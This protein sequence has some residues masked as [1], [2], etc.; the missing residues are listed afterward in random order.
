LIE[1]GHRVT[2]YTRGRALALL[3]GELGERCDYIEGVGYPVPYVRGQHGFVAKFM[4]FIPLIASAIRAEHRDVRRIVDE[5][6][7]DIV[8]GDG[9]YGLFDE[10]IPSYLLA[11]QLRLIAPGRAGLLELVTE[12]FQYHFHKQFRRY[13]VPDYEHDSLTGDLSHNLRLFDDN[14]ISYIGILS[15]FRRAD[16]PS[17]IDYFVSISG[18]EPSRTTFEKE[19]LSQV[20]YL[21]GRVVVALGKPE[22]SDVVT[23]GD[24]DIHS[25]VNGKGGNEFM[26]RAK[27][28]ISRPGYSTLMDLVELGKKALF[29]PTPGQTEQEYLAQYHRQ[30]GTFYSVAQNEINLKLDTELAARYPGAACQHGTA[31]SVRKFMEVVFG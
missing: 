12:Y 29:I 4:S 1:D 13:I 17:D 26:N 21:D 28:V 5:R 18:P 22:R 8:V 27:L 10:R 14:Q 6:D 30:R 24:V 19:V 16:L 20:H 31:D 25:Y 2:I 15:E 9:K 7:I 23:R 11:H 3:R